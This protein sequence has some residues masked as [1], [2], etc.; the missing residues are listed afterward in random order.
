MHYV[1]QNTRKAE[2]ESIFFLI[3]PLRNRSCQLKKKKIAQCEICELNFIW[4]GM[5]TLDWETGS[6][7]SLRNFSLKVGR[8]VSVYVVFMKGHMCN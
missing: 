7:I 6:Q 3:F 4:G 1:P 2:I 5:R 8:K